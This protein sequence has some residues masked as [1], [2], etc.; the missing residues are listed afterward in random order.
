MDYPN[1]I[2]FDGFWD[3]HGRVNEHGGKCREYKIINN[4]P[5]QTSR[6]YVCRL[7]SRG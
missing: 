2:S 6:L 1:F 3:R 7:G 5:H 4:C